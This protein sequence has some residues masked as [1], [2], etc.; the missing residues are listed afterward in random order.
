MTTLTFHC[1]AGSILTALLT[2]LAL[3][4]PTVR[5]QPPQP[6]DGAVTQSA[7]VLNRTDFD[8]I[9]ARVPREQAPI[10]AVAAAQVKI[11][12]HEA[13]RKAEQKLCR[14]RWTTSGPVFSQ[15]IQLSAD[16]SAWQFRMLRHPGGPECGQ[17]SREQFAA[18]MN[19]HLPEWVE[20]VPAGEATATEPVLVRTQTHPP[21]VTPFAALTSPDP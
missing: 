11:A 18:E 3:L 17:V 14:G 13:K 4:A 10:E 12:L 7:A 9:L 2:A 19:R 15:D 1:N 8:R 5:A 16:S 6:P 20:F 21:L